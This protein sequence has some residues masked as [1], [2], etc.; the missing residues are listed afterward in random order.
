MMKQ[1]ALELLSNKAVAGTF[2]IYIRALRDLYQRS[3]K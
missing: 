3:E 2:L 1:G